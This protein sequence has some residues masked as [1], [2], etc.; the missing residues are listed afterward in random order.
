LEHSR[1]R[2]IC[3]D[4]KRYIV[5]GNG[6]N[7]PSN[8]ELVSV[9]NNIRKL[10]DTSADPFIIGFIG[11]LDRAHFFKNVPFI[12]K[13]MKELPDSI[14]LVIVGDGDLKNEYE[15]LT[16]QLHLTERV[17]FLG[18]I[19]NAEIFSIIS[20]FGCLALPSSQVESFGVVLIE[21]MACGIPVVASNIPGVRAL[22]QDGVTGFLFPPDSLEMYIAAI[23]KLQ[24][25]PLLCQ[26]LGQKGRE[27]VAGHF[28]WKQVVDKIEA[29]YYQAIGS[30]ILSKS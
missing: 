2:Y 3:Q 29:G 14:K 7:P 12:I 18:N 24:Q 25:H 1:I 4:E 23:T 13:A 26:Q 27:L 21:A 11:N 19:D 9:K 30:W 20:Q 6:V 5:T 16:E 28:T 10:F 8:R 17:K 22:V 15:Q